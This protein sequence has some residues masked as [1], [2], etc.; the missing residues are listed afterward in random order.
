[1]LVE[2][3]VGIQ[4]LQDGINFQFRQGKSGEV[5]TK[6]SHATFYEAVYRGNV[7]V[8]VTPL[9]GFTFVSGFSTNCPLAIW[10]PSNSPKNLVLQRFEYSL[11]SGTAPSGPLMWGKTSQG[12]TALGGTA[13]APVNCLIGN[14]ANNSVAFCAT[15]AGAVVVTPTLVRMTGINFP[16]PV[17]TVTIFQEINGELI[18]TPGNAL[19][20]AANN[21]GSS[22][23]SI[24]SLVWEEVP[25]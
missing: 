22:D 10:N 6:Q 20:I 11:I 3:K 17:K 15:G 23:K 19:A 8:A 2:G 5:I 12:S 18:I 14:V 25:F 13:I 9:A 16:S 1:M 4:N 24:L 7:Y 21:T